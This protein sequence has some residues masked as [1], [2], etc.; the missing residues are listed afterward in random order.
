MFTLK[1]M[2]FLLVSPV[3]LGL[4]ISFIGIF[5]LWFTKRQRTGKILVSTG[6]LLIL[7]PGYSFVSDKLLGH[8]ENQYAPYDM[9]LSNE[10]L[11]SQNLFP[12]KFV[13]VLGG[14]H[15]SDHKLPVTSQISES[16][17][18]RLIE[19]IIIYRKS[20]GSKLVLS[21]GIVFDP[22]PEAE[23]MARVAEKL[24]VDRKD[25]ILETL[26]KDT[27]DQAIFIKSIVKNK[28]FV[29]VTSAN[30]MP[31][32]MAMFQKSGLSP[33]PAPTKHYIKQRRGLQPD[34]LFPKAINLHKARIAFHEYLGMV[35]AKL[36]KQI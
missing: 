34:S 33:I 18:V 8:L 25:I 17:L 32:A 20:I 7:V 31:R 24:G 10:V 27:G 30:H 2:L 22:V 3:P 15:T 13:V 11:K 14:G 26:S 12:L 23:I 5:F 21:G 16:S 4:L 1:K 9:R 36:R 29:L 35:W 6:L 19:G 28:P